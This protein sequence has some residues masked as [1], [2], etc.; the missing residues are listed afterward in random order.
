VGVAGC[1]ANVRANL[2]LI[3]AEDLKQDYERKIATLELKGEE[4][5]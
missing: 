3:K 5:C 4:S 1:V 2:G